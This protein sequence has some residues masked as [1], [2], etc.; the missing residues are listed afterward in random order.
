MKIPKKTYQAPALTVVEFKIERGYANSDI[1]LVNQAV[2][3]TNRFIEDRV[4][5]SN[6]L[7]TE[8]YLD[9]TGIEDR[10]TGTS[11]D[12]DAGE[13]GWLENDGRYF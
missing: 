2:G 1:S 4:Q 5:E 3:A 13:G 12:N 7:W 10:T 11:F 9:N 6:A 8:S